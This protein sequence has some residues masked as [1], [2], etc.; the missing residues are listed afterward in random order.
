MALTTRVAL[1]VSDDLLFR[2]FLVDAEM[3]WWCDTWGFAERDF[4]EMV[5]NYHYAIGQIGF[6]YSDRH[7]SYFEQETLEFLNESYYARDIAL[8]ADNYHVNLSTFQRMVLGSFI[9]G[10]EIIAIANFQHLARYLACL[11]TQIKYGLSCILDMTIPWFVHEIT[12]DGC[13]I[14]MTLAHTH[15]HDVVLDI[16]S[17]TAESNPYDL[18]RSNV[19]NRVHP[20]ERALAGQRIVRGAF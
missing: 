19:H 10:D 9:P 4:H 6:E 7:I 16:L 11:A 12:I 5:E 18:E 1:G 17:G 8:I 15:E 20:R 2:R 3:P 14:E 13:T